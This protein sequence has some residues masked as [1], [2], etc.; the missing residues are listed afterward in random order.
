MGSKAGFTV[1]FAM[2]DEIGIRNMVVTAADR[3]EAFYVGRDILWKRFRWPGASIRAIRGV[4]PT[5]W[6]PCLHPMHDDDCPDG[7]ADPKADGLNMGG[8]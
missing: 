5:D 3:D 7:C 1:E 2:R 6:V 8:R 4:L